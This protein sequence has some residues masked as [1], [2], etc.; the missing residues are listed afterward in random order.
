MLGKH[1]IWDDVDKELVEQFRNGRR[2]E[3]KITSPFELSLNMGRGFNE[4]HNGS[5]NFQHFYNH[6]PYAREVYIIAY[7][8]GREPI[9]K[10]NILKRVWD[11]NCERDWEWKS[12]IELGIISGFGWFG[13]YSALKEDWS[14][15]E[16]FEIG[17]PERAIRADENYRKQQIVQNMLDKY[18]SEELRAYIYALRESQ[19]PA[20]FYFYPNLH[21]KIYFSDKLVYIGSANPVPGSFSNAEAGITTRSREVMRAVKAYY[22]AL[23]KEGTRLNEI[24]CPENKRYLLEL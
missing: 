8:L 19:W 5:L 12:A 7:S 24:E 14:W 15:D 23:A 16:Q 1:S 10:H 3:L 20:G 21:S 2:L 4:T 6:L 22:M 9:T 11:I 18:L 17:S 13:D